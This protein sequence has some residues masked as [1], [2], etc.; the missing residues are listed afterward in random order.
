MLK[1]VQRT[2]IGITAAP[3]ILEL[4]SAARLPKQDVVN[5][6]K[7]APPNPDIERSCHLLPRD[8]LRKAPAPIE[9][10]YNLSRI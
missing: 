1:M 8:Y 9:H 7:S 10:E 5:I 2:M 4:F 6:Y 3:Y